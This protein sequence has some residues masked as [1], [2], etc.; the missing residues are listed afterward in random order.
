MTLD[1]QAAGDWTH[2]A[3]PGGIRFLVCST[4]HGLQTPTF[5]ALRFLSTT[6][7][8]KQAR[9]AQPPAVGAAPGATGSPSSAVSLSQP[10][11]VPAALPVKGHLSP[12]LV[13]AQSSTITPHCIHYDR[14][15]WRGPVPKAGR[16]SNELEKSRLSYSFRMLKVTCP[17]F[18]HF[19][20]LRP[21][22]MPLY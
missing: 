4:P 19:S 6:G 9:C 12:G 5:S 11:A 21:M 8:Q 10:Q 1:P 14:G 3:V 13:P 16:R 17:G 7:H 15:Q 18:W 22:K 20:F 2:R